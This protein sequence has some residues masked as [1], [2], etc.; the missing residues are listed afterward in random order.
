MTTPALRCP[1]RAPSSIARANDL[2]GRQPGIRG[3]SVLPL[4]NPCPILLRVGLARLVRVVA[5]FI[6]LGAIH[7]DLAANRCHFP[8]AGGSRVVGAATLHQSAADDPCSSGC[9][10]DCYSCSRAEVAAS[11]VLPSRPNIVA[12][13]FV[14]PEAR[15]SEGVRPLPYHPP[16]FL[17]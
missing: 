3:Q 14:G 12:A 2:V 16:L 1:E 11:A 15:P 7:A 10:P 4:C 6:V 13:A 17:L 9:V 8:R 5:A